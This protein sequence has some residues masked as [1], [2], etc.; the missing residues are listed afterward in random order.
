MPDNVRQGNAHP[1]KDEDN[2]RDDGDK[3]PMTRYKI[4]VMSGRI[5]LAL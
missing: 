3:D 5:V 2:N 1:D 4:G